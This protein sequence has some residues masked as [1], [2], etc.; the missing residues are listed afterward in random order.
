[1]ETP[2]PFF[3]IVIA[4][5]NRRIVLERA[6][7]SVENQTFVNWELIVV[8]DAST[9]DTAAWLHEQQKRL[10][11]KLKL[12][13]SDKNRERGYS[14]NI[15]IDMASGLY[16]GFLD[17]DDY[18]LPEHLSVLY[19]EVMNAGMPEALLFTN[20][21]DGFEGGRVEERNC[22]DINSM[23]L[24]NYLL[25]NTF[26]P[27]RVV[28]HRRI[29]EHHRFDPDIP[30]LEDLDLWLRIAKAYP[31]IQ[32]N[33]RSTVYSCHQE[34]YSSSEKRYAKEIQYLNKICR[35]PELKGS[36]PQAIIKNMLFE[37]H[38]GAAIWSGKNSAW[39]DSL[40]YSVWILFNAP[41]V[42]KATHIRSILSG[43][44]EGLK[45]KKHHG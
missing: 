19:T 11:S 36:L 29:L 30:G 2:T 43:L 15:G 12:H 6:L 37:R 14:R 33:H 44:K 26:N 5:Y 10:G 22:P 23:P 7:V 45:R 9:D 38:L 3:S 17:S 35:K 21:Y 18:H 34:A 42:L 24:M 31:I 40:R 4:T 27:Q 32:I 39:L 16:I 13:I 25:L 20:A 41:L 1:M 8:D 28:V